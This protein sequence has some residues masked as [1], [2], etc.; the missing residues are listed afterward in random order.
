MVA[1]DYLRKDIE[2]NKKNYVS[3]PLSELR[4]M[5]TTP[6]QVK[7]LE[8]QVI[9]SAVLTRFCRSCTNSE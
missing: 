9:A 1:D 2:E 4:K 5:Y 8:E 3:L 6:A 7:F